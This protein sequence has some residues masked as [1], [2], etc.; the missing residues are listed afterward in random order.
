[1]ERSHET[2]LDKGWW[3]GD[4]TI[5]EQFANFHSEISEAWEEIRNN[6]TLSE[7]YFSDSDIGPKP[8]GVAV[9]L[10]DL[11]I[12]VFDTCEAYE[13]PLIEAINEKLEYNKMRPYRHGGKMA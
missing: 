5:G 11:L 10:A 13:I 9:E 6:K 4:R 8:E 12:R 2:A 1:M 3:N 7:I